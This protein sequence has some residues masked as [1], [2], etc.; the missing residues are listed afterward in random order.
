M[1]DEYIDLLQVRISHLHHTDPYATLIPLT[2]SLPVPIIFGFSFFIKH[3][4]L[5]MLKLKRHINQQDLK[6]VDPHFVR[7]E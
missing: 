1:W 3:Q 5:N 4:L 7:S 2:P 6:T